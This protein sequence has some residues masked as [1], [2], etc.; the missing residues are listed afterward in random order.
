MAE[1]SVRGIKWQCLG[2]VQ[3]SVD[4]CLGKVLSQCVPV[5]RAD[6]IKMVNMVTAR[7]GFRCDN[8]AYVFEKLIITRGNRASCLSP[9][10]EIGQFCIQDGRLQAI[11]TAVDRKSTR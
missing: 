7:T 9:C 3:T 1:M 5:F 11:Q 6:D 4:A 8:I 2:V 10:I